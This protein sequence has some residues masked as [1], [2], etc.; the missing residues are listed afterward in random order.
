MGEY[1]A[2]V[3]FTCDWSSSFPP[4]LLY[5]S[6]EFRGPGIQ[7]QRR[8]LSGSPS[9]SPSLP[10]LPLLSPVFSSSLSFLAVFVR[11]FLPTFVRPFSFLLLLV[12]LFV[13]FLFNFH[14]SLVSFSLLCSVSLF[15]TC[16]FF[17]PLLP[18]HLSSFPS[19]SGLRSIFYSIV[20]FFF[21]SSSQLSNLSFPFTLFPL[22]VLLLI[23]LQCPLF[24]PPFLYMSA[25]SLFLPVFS[26]CSFLLP[27]SPSCVSVGVDVGVDVG[28]GVGV[29]I[30]LPRLPKCLSVV[31]SSLSLPE[32]WI[33]SFVAAVTSPERQA[34]SNV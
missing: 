20:V 11:E 5:A 26:K 32:E 24:F 8:R 31:L 29:C 33:M 2:S 1:V 34:G 18:L 25:F 28:V 13:L 30:C 22:P 19:F 9:H 21:L 7:E 16:L 17:F 23:F 14:F 6:H 4:L 3:I 15:L 12:F 27:Q 10:R